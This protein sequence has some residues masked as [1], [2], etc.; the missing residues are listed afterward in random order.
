MA[1]EARM[2]VHFHW[3]SLLTQLLRFARSQTRLK[4]VKTELVQVW[5]NSIRFTISAVKSKQTYQPSKTITTTW[6]LEVKYALQFMPVSC[7]LLPLFIHTL[8]LNP[9]ST[10]CKWGKGLYYTAFSKTVFS[11][12]ILRYNTCISSNHNIKHQLT[13]DKVNFIM[14]LEN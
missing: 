12:A 6:W 5:A 7:H 13:I 1:T 8:Y 10:Y 9:P 2:G 4:G 11:F 3:G 14:N